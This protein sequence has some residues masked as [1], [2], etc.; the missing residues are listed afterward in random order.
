MPLPKRLTPKARY[1]EDFIDVYNAVIT[2]D[3]H[4]LNLPA[5]HPMLN[6]SQLVWAKYSVLIKRI[7]LA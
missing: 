2:I 7:Y 3:I 1:L 6:L 5:A 4:L